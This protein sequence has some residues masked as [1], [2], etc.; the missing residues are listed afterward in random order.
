M[1]N[2]IDGL[3][4][5]AAG[6]GQDMAGQMQ[7]SMKDK[8]MME[9]DEGG[10]GDDMDM[11]DEDA[12]ML[13]TV[14]RGV[15]KFMEAEDGEEVELTITVRKEDDMKACVLKVD[16]IKTPYAE[17]EQGDDG[18]DPNAKPGKAFLDAIGGEGDDEEGGMM[19][20]MGKGGY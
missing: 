4:A 7:K 13:I 15:R 19:G 20:G 3:E 10:D 14:P 1:A 18:D 16:G 8:P 2:A 17:K 11:E 5:M 6:G 9:D 12:E